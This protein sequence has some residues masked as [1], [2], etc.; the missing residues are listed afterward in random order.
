M[1]L[2]S[3]GSEGSRRFLN[4]AKLYQLPA[5]HQTAL[6]VCIGLS[7]M[8]VWMNLVG[9][10]SLFMPADINQEVLIGFSK[11][12][13]LFYAG[14][15]SSCLTFVIFGNKLDYFFKEKL[16]KL[17]L[18]LSG[19]M[20]LNTLAFAAAFFQ[21]VLDP[22]IVA[23]VACFVSGVCYNLLVF[24]LYVRL[25]E[26]ESMKVVIACIT[27]SLV[28]EMIFN[29]VFNA[30]LP[31]VAH[32]T[33]GAI[34]PLLCGFILA[35]MLRRLP[36]QVQEQATLVGKERNYHIMLVVVMSFGSIA[37]MAAKRAGPTA[38]LWGT[39]NDWLP[40]VAFNIVALIAISA[41]FIFLAWLT[42]VRR[43]DDRIAV[44]YQLPFLVII[45]GCLL[46]ILNELILP[47]N[48]F[49]L[50]AIVV[51]AIDLFCHLLSWTIALSLIKTVRISVYRI[52]GFR[53]LVF[54]MLAIVWIVLL[55]GNNPLVSSAIL[56]VVFIIVI[57]I[58]ALPLNLNQGQREQGAPEG[59]ALDKRERLEAIAQKYGLSARENE[60]FVLLA[61]GR[62]RPYIQKQL[63][64]AD[65]T[66][67]THSSHIYTKLDV[68]SRQEMLDL[69]ERECGGL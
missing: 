53:G 37:V 39:R 45:A 58:T 25:A 65:G 48:T 41:I 51:N 28:A 27:T 31:A 44:R 52:L 5:H 22:L 24:A 42:L 9:Y 15:V 38:G 32:I 50:E 55:E 43:T 18:I 4:L 1:G 10:S 33:V 69:I 60:V 35:V 6:W 68:H 3:T 67:K 16:P 54:N 14:I 21:S 13:L 34:M 29:D 40:S 20:C 63:Y 30:L 7:A 47:H 19:V 62:N 2:S 26:Q 36:A 46:M 56:L 66:V 61:Q 8:G 17:G 64:L 49:S 12:R 59:T 11:T 23:L 57:A